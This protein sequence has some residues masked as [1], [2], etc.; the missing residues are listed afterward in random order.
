MPEI[1]LDWPFPTSIVRENDKDGLARIRGGFRQPRSAPSLC[2]GV[3]D[4]AASAPRRSKRG[5]P[6]SYK[7]A[8]GW[9]RHRRCESGS[10]DY[11]S[12]VSAP[13]IRIRYPI[14]ETSIKDFLTTSKSAPIL[15]YKALLSLANWLDKRCESEAASRLEPTSCC[16]TTAADCSAGSAGKTSAEDSPGGRGASR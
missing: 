15:G 2:D 10:F 11:R 9:S 8:G 6:P 4:W 1:G 14:E 12:P 13:K 3:E 7:T 16:A 5:S